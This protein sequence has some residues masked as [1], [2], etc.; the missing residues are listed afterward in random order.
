ML[1]MYAL[2]VTVIDTSFTHSVLKHLPVNEI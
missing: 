1:I 2:F